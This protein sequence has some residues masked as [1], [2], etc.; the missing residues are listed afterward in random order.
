MVSKLRGNLSFLEGRMRVRKVR[1]GNRVYQMTVP[2]AEPVQEKAPPA[3][4]SAVASAPETA[5]ATDRLGLAV[6]AARLPVFAAAADFAEARELF[7]RLAKVLDRIAQ[8]P[9]GAVYRQKL[10]RK[11]QGSQVI[12]ESTLLQ[13][14]LAELQAAEPYCGYCPLC[15][16]V[17]SAFSSPACPLC[18]GRGWTTEPAFAACPEGHR[19]AML[20]MRDQK[21]G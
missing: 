8:Q 9:A 4:E 1:R 21:P 16:V 14:A 7:A 17:F 11:G 6:P 2:E 15:E 10:S 13:G 12:F 19:Q 20:R 5:T 18:Q 3:A